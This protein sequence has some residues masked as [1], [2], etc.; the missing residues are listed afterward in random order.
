[1]F[2]KAESRDLA[3][4]TVGAR[5]KSGGGSAER[6]RDPKTGGTNTEFLDGA[7]V[8]ALRNDAGCW[9]IQILED[10]SKIY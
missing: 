6:A 1:L 9:A 2:T 3:E 8:C 5:I 4:A 7:A 10:F